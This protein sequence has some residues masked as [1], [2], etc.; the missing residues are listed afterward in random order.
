[1]NESAAIESK[2]SCLVRGCGAASTLSASHSTAESSS[3]SLIL[4]EAKRSATRLACNCTMV[5]ICCRS[6][7]CAAKT[8]SL[9]A[10]DRR[11]R[12]RRKVMQDRRYNHQRR[13][14]QNDNN[15]SCIYLKDDE[16][17]D[18]VDKF[19]PEVRANLQRAAQGA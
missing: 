7:P 10:F 13:S 17:V 15:S 9:L 4:R 6:K 1:M 8:S 19:W 14:L 3:S 11:C 2:P 18:A 16:L 12:A 5:P